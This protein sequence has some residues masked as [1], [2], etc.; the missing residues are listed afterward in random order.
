MKMARHEFMPGHFYDLWESALSCAEVT[1]HAQLDLVH[2]GEHRQIGAFAL[3]FFQC[4]SPARLSAH[5]HAQAQRVVARERGRRRFHASQADI[6]RVE[7]LAKIVVHRFIPVIVKT[8]LRAHARSEIQ[9]GKVDNADKTFA[10]T[11]I[12]GLGA[13]A[14]AT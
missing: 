6:G 1:G 10:I 3:R 9:P 8:L 5:D 14:P 11:Q 4:H 12:D 7:C 13:T 2:C